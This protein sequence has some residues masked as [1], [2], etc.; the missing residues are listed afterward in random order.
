M[1]RQLDLINKV[2]HVFGPYG[3]KL[4]AMHVFVRLAIDLNVF[5]YNS[6]MQI[7]HKLSRELL[8]YDRY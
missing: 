7:Y 8:K 5:L 2:L 4:S 6:P 1:G 3:R